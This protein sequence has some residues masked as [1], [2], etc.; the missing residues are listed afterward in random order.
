MYLTLNFWNSVCIFKP[1]NLSKY[2]FCRK[3]E[4]CLTVP[5]LSGCLGIDKWLIWCFLLGAYR[6]LLRW[7]RIHMMDMKCVGPLFNV[8]SLQT[9]LLTTLFK[10]TA[11][12]FSMPVSVLHNSAYI[13]Q[14]F[15]CHLLTH[16]ALKGGP[17]NQENA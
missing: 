8:W 5:M 12:W 7:P 3:C 14:A 4:W 2:Y 6:A 9:P 13:I 16:W 17:L 10:D 15:L 11:H 1:Q